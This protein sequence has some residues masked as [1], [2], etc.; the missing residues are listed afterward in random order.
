MQVVEVSFYNV[1]ERLMENV[2]LFNGVLLTTNKLALVDYVEKVEVGIKG[3]DVLKSRIRV[4]IVNFAEDT[5]V[6]N[7]IIRKEAVLF[8]P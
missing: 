5:T 4:L 8:I 2:E 1:T 3:T 7:S 6:Q